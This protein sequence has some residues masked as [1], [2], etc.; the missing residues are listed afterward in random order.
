[1]GRWSNYRA[2]RAQRKASETEKELTGQRELVWGK[3]TDAQK[4]FCES[5][6]ESR[7]MGMRH[8]FTKFRELGQSIRFVSVLMGATVAALSGFAGVQMRIIVAVLGVVLAAVNAAPSIF[9]TELRVIINRRYVGRLLNQGW[10]FAL[11]V[12]RSEDMAT[13]ESTA[14]R[15][16]YFETFRTAV[17]ALL[18]DFDVDYEKNIYE[19]IKS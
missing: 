5:R 3:L 11:A 15:D 19:A 8:R 14:A 1:M 10:I 4:G 16:L 9:S 13:V 12:R 2:Q 18:A 17:E 6:Y 7:V